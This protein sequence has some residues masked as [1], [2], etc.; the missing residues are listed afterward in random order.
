MFELFYNIFFLQFQCRISIA[1]EK[2]SKKIK[3]VFLQ[4]IIEILYLQE[5][6]GVLLLIIN[7]VYYLYQQ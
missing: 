1:K 6:L 3:Y 4:Y 5:F 7:V 2:R